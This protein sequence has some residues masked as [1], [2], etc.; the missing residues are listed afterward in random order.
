MALRGGIVAVVL[1]ISAVAC[2]GRGPV[3]VSIEFRNSWTI[4]GVPLAAAEQ[5]VV[6][7]A[8]VG[9]LRAAFSAFDVRVAE[10]DR[11][12]SHRI[13]VSDTPYSAP[14]Y[15]GGVGLTRAT[16]A[17]SSVHADGLF[18]AELTVLGCESM[19]RCAAKTREKL[20][21]GLGVG[22]GATAAHELGHQRGLA[23]THHAACDSCY[24]S[25]TSTSFTHFFG[26]KHWSPDSLHA[27]RAVLQ[28]RPQP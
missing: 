6:R 12:A 7:S 11:I 3:T 2:G 26:R 1:A 5:R 20:V 24:D 16:A 8:A 4:G 10:D 22:I 15:F 9:T 18:S 27:M 28:P 25:A 23:F 19:L 13:V 14:M 17:D 21:V